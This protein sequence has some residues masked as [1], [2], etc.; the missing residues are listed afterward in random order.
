MVHATI[1]ILMLLSHKALAASISGTSVTEFVIMYQSFRSD[2]TAMSQKSCPINQIIE[3]LICS[4]VYLI[5]SR[6]TEVMELHAQPQPDRSSELSA[7][8]WAG[9][10]TKFYKKRLRQ[11]RD[12]SLLYELCFKNSWHTKFFMVSEHLLSPQAPQ[13]A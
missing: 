4:V 5:L 13:A 10:P 11:Y 6:P 8:P 12:Y 1:F 7:T 9:G 3:D 2:G